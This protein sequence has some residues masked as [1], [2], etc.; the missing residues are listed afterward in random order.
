MSIRVTCPKCQKLFTARDEQAGRTTRCPSC[1]ALCE[2]PAAGNSASPMRTA[3]PPVTPSPFR[4]ARP[5]DDD[6]N[7]D[8]EGLPPMPPPRP[9]PGMPGTPALPPLPGFPPI[10]GLP[11]NPRSTPIVGI[12]NIPLPGMPPK[13]GTPPGSMPS[14]P[15]LPPLP[16]MPPAPPMAPP[17]GRGMPMPPPPAKPAAPPGMP[18]MPGMN[19][20]TGMPGMNPPSGM[21]GGMPGGMPSG[22][23]PFGGK[24]PAPG[25]PPMGTP[26]PSSRGKVPSLPSLPPIPIP[27]MRDSGPPPGFGSPFPQD[28]D[29]PAAIEELLNRPRNPA[30]APDFAKPQ[31]VPQAQPREVLRPN[32][33]SAMV[34]GLGLIQV[35][36]VML[37]LPW[38]VQLTKLAMAQAQLLTVTESGEQILGINRSTFEDITLLALT[39]PAICGFLIIASGLFR[40][41]C[42]ALPPS[43]RQMIFSSASLALVSMSGL[44]LLVMPR[45]FPSLESTVPLQLF[46]SVLLLGASSLAATWFVL[47]LVLVAGRLG[48]DRIAYRSGLLL[49]VPIL[50]LSGILFG[51]G[52]FQAEFGTALWQSQWLPNPNWP[53]DPALL[54]PA[55]ILAL[56]QFVAGGIQMVLMLNLASAMRQV[57]R[58]RLPESA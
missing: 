14:M 18:A 15:M 2:V 13:P 8:V 26:P 56:V 39:L 33:W 40:M 16:G 57:I 34:S 28:V 58:K 1:A 5:V 3:P 47:T 7:F 21:P 41:L 30:P 53:S 48:F 11:S 19:P 46:G 10:G 38:I 44:I 32:V 37:I 22:F 20:P 31:P 45:Y 42:P 25:G 23:P 54:Q 9:T 12:P 36:T 52:F 6:D 24:S 51:E 50:G 29:E 35:G 17:A 49:L 4:A 55:A 27:G 43:A